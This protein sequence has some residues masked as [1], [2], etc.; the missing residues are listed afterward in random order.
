MWNSE[1]HS[2]SCDLQHPRKLKTIWELPARYGCMFFFRKCT[3]NRNRTKDDLGHIKSKMTLSVSSMEGLSENVG[4]TLKKKRTQPLCFPPIFFYV[5]CLWAWPK[6]HWDWFHGPMVGFMKHGAF[7]RKV[8]LDH[9]SSWKSSGWWLT[10]P[11]EKYGFVSWGD[12]SIPNINGIKKK[13]MFLKPPIS[14]D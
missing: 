1:F 14:H 10:Y 2:V 5:W 13:N 11:S 12:Y 8:I 6:N 7:S 4:K 9:S 3:E